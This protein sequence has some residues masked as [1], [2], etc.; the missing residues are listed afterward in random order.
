M[1]GSGCGW[2][3]GLLLV[4]RV[5]ALDIAHREYVELSPKTLALLRAHGAVPSTD[6]W[7]HSLVRADG[8]IV[9]NL[10]FRQVSMA[11]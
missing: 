7:F 9:G 2:L 3:C 11:A 4:L 10:E 1:G 6:G 5:D 8:K